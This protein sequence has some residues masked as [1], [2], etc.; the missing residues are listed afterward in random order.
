MPIFSVEIMQRLRRVIP[1]VLPLHRCPEIFDGVEI[2]SVGGADAL[3]ESQDFS[4]SVCFSCLAR[5]MCGKSI[6][7]KNDRTTH[8]AI[9]L[10]DRSSAFCRIDVLPADAEKQPG[11]LSL[12]SA[13]NHRRDGTFAVR[14]ARRPDDRRLPFLFQLR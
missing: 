13:E 9:E 5:P 3:P 6:P 1:Q 4:C 14:A 11:F 12:R 7:E 8:V 10:S 2:G